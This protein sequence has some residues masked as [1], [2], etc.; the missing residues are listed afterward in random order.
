MSKNIR[1]HRELEV[2]RLAFEAAM[3]LFELSK[4]FPIDERFGMTS[5]IRRS[6]RSVCANISEAWRRR[7]YEAAFIAKLSDAE[8]EAAETQVHVEFCV[9]CSYLD[10]SRA[11]TLYATYNSIIAMLVSMAHHSSQWTIRKRTQS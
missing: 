2:Y 10:R 3:D 6:S 8:S 9:A 1:S 11:R 5:Q 4:S 7:R